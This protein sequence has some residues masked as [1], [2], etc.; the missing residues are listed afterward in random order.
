M[1]HL[2]CSTSDLRSIIRVLLEYSV[3][4]TGHISIYGIYVWL[5]LGLYTMSASSCCQCII[6]TALWCNYSKYM[7]Y[8]FIK[9]SRS[10]E[11]HISHILLLNGYL[12]GLIVN[13]FSSSS[14]PSRE[15]AMAINISMAIAD[16]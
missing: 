4:I 10:S 2:L 13:I 15:K 6:D 7:S 1:S 14:N 11:E 8:V 12:N 16:L 5:W 9:Y 3:H